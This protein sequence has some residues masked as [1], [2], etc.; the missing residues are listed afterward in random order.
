MSFQQGNL[1]LDQLPAEE[2]ERV[3]PYLQLVSLEKDQWVCE[4]DS[5]IAHFHF[6]L[7]AVVLL[8]IEMSDGFHT[9][10]ALADCTGMFPL[11]AVADSHC[12]LGVRVFLPG[13]AYRIPVDVLRQE[14][15]RGQA[16]SKLV[17]RAVRILLAQLSMGT[18][19]FR[20][21]STR[22]IL[23]KLLLM[24]LE[25]RREEGL[26]I[27]HAQIADIVGVRREAITLALKQLEHKGALECTRG[28]IRLL[29]RPTLEGLACNCFRSRTQLGTFQRL[30]V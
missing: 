15:S 25:H 9:D 28:K 20:R 22:Q 7:T 11:S 2:V 27:T 17:M 30:L 10:V 3:A 23:A 19:C 24:T 12:L 4:Q 14:F 26:D 13:L 5:I 18:A 6:P 8:S 16:F 29:D 21:H 1:L